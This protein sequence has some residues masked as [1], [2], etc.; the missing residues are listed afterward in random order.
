M[1]VHLVSFTRT[2]FHMLDD[3]ECLAGRETSHT[4]VVLRACTRRQRVDRRRM[5]EDLVLRH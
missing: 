4:D 3:H 5:T 2:Y 1:I